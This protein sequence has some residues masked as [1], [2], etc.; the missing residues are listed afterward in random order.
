MQRR[1]FITLLGSAAAWP[2]TARAQQ[3]YGMRRVSVLMGYGDHD[4]QGEAQLAGF[5]KGL[6]DLGWADGRNLRIDIRW[7][8]GSVERAQMLA[9]ELVD[10]QPDAIL[11]HTT[12]VTAALQRETRTIPVVFV[13]V[14]DPIGSGF[15]AGMPHPGG[16][17]TG[18]VNLEPTMGGKWLEL[19]IELAPDLKRVE[20]MFNPDTAPYVESYYLPSFETAARSLNITPVTARVHTENEIEAAFAS[21]AREPQSGLVIPADSFTFVH[22]APIISLAAR[23]KIPAVYAVRGFATD[24]GLLSYGTDEADLFRRAASYVDRVFRGEKPAEL[25]VQVPAKFEMLLNAKTAKALS[26]DVPASYYW[27]ADEVIE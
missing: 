1:D 14:S 3:S 27:R 10:L 16:N 8:A 26:L 15:V 24:G 4:P 22:R 18:F 11:A 17:I 13:T 19:L 25:P 5:M 9:K 7:T 2:V 20:A 12:P 6:S 21:L 23:N